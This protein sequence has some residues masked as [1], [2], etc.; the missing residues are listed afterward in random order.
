MT[1]TTTT[2]T[3]IATGQTGSNT[4]K[5]ASSLFGSSYSAIQAILG[6]AALE[7]IKIGSN[8]SGVTIGKSEPDKQKGGYS[9]IYVPPY[10]PIQQHKI[11][12]SEMQYR[13][14]II[15]TVPYDVVTQYIRELGFSSGVSLSY[16]S[17]DNDASITN[18]IDIT[19]AENKV[20]ALAALYEKAE[21]SSLAAG[22]YLA[23]VQ[24]G[25]NR[26]DEAQQ[27]IAVYG[28]SAS[29]FSKDDLSIKDSESV[30]DEEARK[31]TA[32]RIDAALLGYAA[33]NMSADNVHDL[34]DVVFLQ[35]DQIGRRRH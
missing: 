26:T 2:T 9:G 3:N 32:A 8:R 31:V 33:S 27:M 16:A 35:S 15:A 23:T 17:G 22:L 19:D 29:G 20:A 21:K 1:T 30:S 25:T 6:S 24:Y 34:F 5:T 10:Y 18:F 12:Q 4:N 13:F 7:G 28:D 14:P 11:D